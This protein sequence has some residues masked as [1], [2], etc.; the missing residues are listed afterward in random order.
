MRTQ[1]QFSSMAIVAA[2]SLSLAACSESPTPSADEAP[3]SSTSAEDS[4]ASQADTA[5][6]TT[7]APSTGGLPADAPALVVAKE[8]RRS[9]LKSGSTNTPK[10]FREAYGGPTLPVA[11]LA[12]PTAEAVVQLR[13]EAPLNQRYEVSPDGTMIAVWVEGTAV[14]PNRFDVIAIPTGEVIESVEDT[15]LS[16]TLAVTWSPDSRGFTFASS[17]D[18]VVHRIGG[19][20]TRP[21]SL[22][23]AVAVRYASNDDVTEWIRCNPTILR[24][25][26]TDEEGT[27]SETS[28]DTCVNM[29]QLVDSGGEWLVVGARYPDG[30]PASGEQLVVIRAGQE[31]KAVLVPDGLTSDDNYGY[32]VLGCGPFGLV[33]DSNSRD[34]DSYIFDSA[35]DRVVPAPGV[36]VEECPIGSSDGDAV[37]YAVRD[38]GVNVVTIS[39][40]ELV[41][42]ARSGRPIA[43]GSDGES[44]LVDGGG[45]FRVATDGSGAAE[46]SV[47]AA[48][49]SGQTNSYCRIGDTGEVVVFTDDG[50]VVHDVAADVSYDVVGFGLPGSCA[51]SQD[52]RWFLAGPLLVD[53]E[54]AESWLLPAIGMPEGERGKVEEF[55]PGLVVDYRFADP[56]PPLPAVLAQ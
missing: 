11:W 25:A 2:L 34:N 22:R 28:D 49:V 26:V 1:T 39:T 51:L 53:V 46:A 29:G 14:E 16:P 24:F 36:D 20:T 35:S 43:F 55:D 17:S 52:G 41:E 44:L 12:D 8:G 10:Y 7:V 4:A 47:Q 54:R 15:T 42:V 13:L 18:A 27:G 6:V 19:Q 56:M 21:E 48:A 30:I 38:G 23:R 37:A 45:T 40:A 33:I 9:P 3:A 50:L 5:A 31:P 32:K